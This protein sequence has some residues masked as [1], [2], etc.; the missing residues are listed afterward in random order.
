MMRLAFQWL[1]LGCRWLWADAFP[2]SQEGILAKVRVWR[3]RE[4]GR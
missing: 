2:T 3:D 1:L 4:Y